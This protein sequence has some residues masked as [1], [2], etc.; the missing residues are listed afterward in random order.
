MGPPV[1]KDHS[2][3]TGSH[4][5]FTPTFPA[6]AG[7]GLASETKQKERFHSQTPTG[8]SASAVY[9]GPGNQ[10]SLDQGMERTRSR[11]GEHR[12]EDSFTPH[13]Q[14][15]TRRDVEDRHGVG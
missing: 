2:L 13:A 11:R 14:L 9:V 6:Q 8:W 10:P 7:G 15:G 12:K 4:R 3:P 5:A 1:P